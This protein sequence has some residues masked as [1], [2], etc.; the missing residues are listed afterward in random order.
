LVPW[1]N[2][3]PSVKKASDMSKIAA[4][5]GP[6]QEAG[7][8]TERPEVCQRYCHVYREGELDELLAQVPELAVDEVYFDTGNWCAIAH[9]RAD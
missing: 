8:W 7:G 2:K 1:N 9:R 3:T 6:Q 4:S 5:G